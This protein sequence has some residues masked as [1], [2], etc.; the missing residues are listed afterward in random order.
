MRKIPE[1]T[2]RKI[3][4]NRSLYMRYTILFLC[5]CCT[6]FLP[7]LIYHKSFVYKIDGAPQYVV[8]LQYMGRYV[9]KA[10]NRAKAIMEINKQNGYVLHKYKGY[11]YYKE[12]PSLMIW[13]VI[14]KILVDCEL[15]KS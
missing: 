4:M 13:D 2:V 9:I 7:F 10:V 11:T 12:N 15:M 14:E 1:N 5:V 8:Y 6:V 3:Q